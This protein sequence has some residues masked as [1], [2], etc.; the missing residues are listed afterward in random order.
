MGE[1]EIDGEMDTSLEVGKVDCV[2]LS[3]EGNSESRNDSVALVVVSPV[4]L[5]C[6]T[7][8]RHRAAE[9]FLAITEA[10]LRTELNVDQEASA[11]ARDVCVVLS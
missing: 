8:S 7:S 6:P 9:V 2:V 5:I 10:S 11:A 3:I 1:G 4:E